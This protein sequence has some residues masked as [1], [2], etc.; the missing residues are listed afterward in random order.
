MVMHSKKHLL[1][2]S[3]MLAGPF[4]FI[5]TLLFRPQMLTP[6]RSGIELIVP[7]EAQTLCAVTVLLLTCFLFR[8]LIFR[9]SRIVSVLISIGFPFVCIGLV[10]VSI[11]YRL[12]LVPVIVAV[13]LAVAC[14]YMLRFV[15]VWYSLG[16]ETAL[17]DYAISTIISFGVSALIVHFGY[18]TLLT[19][20]YSSIALCLLI[21]FSG[22]LVVIKT[23]KNPRAKSSG[24]SSPSESVERLAH[25]A[26]VRDEGDFIYLANAIGPVVPAALI[27]A[28]SL[29]TAL[30][31]PSIEQTVRSVLPFVVGALCAIAFLAILAF[32]WHR[33]GEEQGSEIIVFMSV[34]CALGIIA[35]MYSASVPFSAVYAIVACSNLLFLALLWIDMLYF[36]ERRSFSQSVL[37]VVAVGVV[38]LLFCIAMLVSDFVPV[39][40]Y[41]VITPIAALLYLIWLVFYF[42]REL[43]RPVYVPND[44]HRVEKEDEAA[45]PTERLGFSE[46]RNKA[47]DGMACDFGLSPKEAEILPLLVTGLPAPAIG[48]HAYI[49]YET[50]KTHKYHIYQ[51]CN[52]RNFEELLELFERYAEQIGLEGWEDPRLEV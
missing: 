39:T 6:S 35:S 50:V 42:Q 18:A 10:V 29:G 3:L 5:Q 32:R 9:P 15:L 7:M 27:C 23:P 44:F 1:L 8:R 24:T 21:L 2:F 38:L 16:P 4:G 19:E 33:R 49:S 43:A 31:D 14:G 36:A 51:K 47:C 45:V 34:P 11:V 40:V 25:A 30:V 12:L 26:I 22:I 52:V 48:K 28:F 46:I 37:P 41:P 20:A 17:E 13:I